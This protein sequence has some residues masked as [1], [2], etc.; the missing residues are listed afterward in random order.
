MLGAALA[1]AGLI[2]AGAGAASADESM[3]VPAAPVQGPTQELTAF[4]DRKDDTGLP[5]EPL[6]GDG[7]R[8]AR[9]TL[10]I[11][12][13]PLGPGGLDPAHPPIGWDTPVQVLEDSTAGVVGG[14]SANVLAPNPTTG[15]SSIGI[16]AGGDE[17]TVTI[18]RQYR[19][20][21]DRAVPVHYYVLEK[22]GVD[23]L[24]VQYRF[25]YSHQ[26][27]THGNVNGI[28]AGDLDPDTWHSTSAADVQWLADQG[29]E[30]PRIN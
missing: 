14:W 1:C 9:G 7:V 27:I 20:K 26:R 18:Q 17:L 6:Y 8:D 4:T 21:I 11:T 24:A 12:D 16:P 22:G 23:Y 10:R 19:V 2:A 25:E 30:I 15:D 28:P 29:V 3:T 13:L 5:G